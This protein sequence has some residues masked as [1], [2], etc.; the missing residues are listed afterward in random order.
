[1]SDEDR[2]VHAKAN[3]D[4]E[5]TGE[6]VEAHIRGGRHAADE[7]AGDDSKKQ[8]KGGDRSNEEDGSDDVEAHVRLG[9]Q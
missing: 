9:R 2:K 5:E 6:D 3:D 8:V 1:M 4:V 7:G